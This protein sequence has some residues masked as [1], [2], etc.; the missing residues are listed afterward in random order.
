M[1]DNIFTLHWPALLKNLGREN[2]YFWIIA[3]FHFIV[4]LF[5][6]EIIGLDIA[7]REWDGLW[8]AIPVDLIQT[9]F[10]RSLWY[11][12]AQPPLFNVYGAVFIKLFFPAHLQAMYLANIILG[13]LLS[14]MLFK[15]LVRFSGNVKFSFAVAFALAL[16]PALILYEA[17][18]LYTLLTAFLVVSSV[19]CLALFDASRNHRYLYLFILTINALILTRTLYHIVIL[20]FAIPLALFLAGKKWRRM[21]VTAVLISLFSVGWYGKNWFYFGFFGE[22]SWTGIG[23]WKI[24]SPGYGREE[25]QRLAET[26]EVDEAVVD[27]L[28]FS[29]PSLFYP[30][31]FTAVS[32]VP[33]M[34]RNDYNNVNIL[35]ISRMYRKS[36]LNLIRL[37]PERYFLNTIMAYVVFTSPPS[38]FYHLE[39]NAGRMG[40]HEAFVSQIIL[41]Q[42]Y[43]Q[44]IVPFRDKTMGSILVIILPVT[45]LIYLWETVKCNRLSRR[46]WK[47]YILTEAP[48][49]ATVFLILYT[50]AV[51]ITLEYIENS[52]FQFL[53]GHLM[54][55]F[56][57]AVLY[58]IFAA[59]KQREER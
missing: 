51:S 33:V 30:Y 53:T 36:A 59:Q 2:R 34:N 54:W 57:A 46:K 37:H 4:A 22:S 40:F 28:V 6:K 16:S 21:L 44:Q 55:A 58:R 41:G 8:Q 38:R 17:Y 35:A 15:I 32:D 29:R 10:W 25:L 1:A 9:D 13:S 42:K 20:L 18:P 11:F 56:I 45:L 52:R 3:G 43:I 19:F 48:L 47:E 24:V 31:G 26:G 39:E 5:Y 7:W 27:L 14:G 49:I 12:H 50:T 23:L